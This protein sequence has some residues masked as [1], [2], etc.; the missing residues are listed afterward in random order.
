MQKIQLYIEGQRVDLF[1]DE[2]VVL[3]QT[4]QNVKDVQ[5]VFTDYSKTFTLPATKENN[6]IFKH[7]YNNSITN[8]FDGRGRVDATLELNHLKFRKGKIKL[9]GVDLRNNVPHTYKVR[10][11]GNT[12]TLKDLL[13]EDKLGALSDL[14]S[15][16]LVYNAANVKTKLKANPATSDIIAPLITHTK[17]LYY[18]ANTH[19]EG[20]S[21]LWY[22]SGSGTSHHHGVSWDDLKYAIRVDTIIQAI[23]TNYGISF[24]NDFFN[25]SNTPYY[26]L[27]MWLHR[28][29]GYVESPTATEVESLVNTWTTTSIGQTLSL[30]S[31]TSTLYIGGTPSRYTKLDLKLRTTS[32]FSYSVSVQLNG[33]EIYNSGS[34]TGNLDITK[35]NIGTSQGNYNV[36]IQS[37]QNITFSEVT[38]NIGYRLL[39]ESFNTYTSASFSHTNAFDF[40]ITQ[41][42]PE[43]KCIDF[44]TGIFKMF[45]LTSYI[46]NDTDEVIVKTLDDFYSDGVSYDIT[47]FVDRNKSSVNVALPFK[48]ITFE[49]GDTKTFLASKH[50]QLYNNTWG[51]I[52]YTSGEN[53]DGKIYKV[54]TPFSH[55]LY[56]RLI[57]LDTDA[58]TTVQYG[59]YVDDNQSPYYGK[60]LLF[61][62]ILQNTTSI[63]FLDTTSSHS[64]VTQYNIPSN[65]VA[66]SSST[67]KYNIN[68]NNEINEY[69]LDNTFT[70]TLFQAYHS[71]YISDVFD[72]TNR[73]TKVTAYLPLRILL[74]YTLADRFNI[75]GTT[76]KINSIKTNMLT[77]KSDLELLNDIYTPPAPAIPPDTTP[78]TAPIVNTSS[79]IRGTTQIYFCW[80]ASTDTGVGVKSYSVTQDSV[81]VQRVSATPYQD[82]YCVTITGLTSGTS[83]TFGITATDFNNNVSTTTNY[84]ISTL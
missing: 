11:T 41:Q 80:A 14:N 50:S 49:H 5:K 15:N 45:N 3:T 19:G 21:N 51:K 66:L 58:L 69:T 83:Y 54:K 74:N 12:V 46:D 29:K 8:G 25:S 39:V 53:L 64:E 48:E 38:W 4:I 35:D 52:E 67:S 30:M 63:S 60:P 37:A 22:E 23:E 31:N 55:M 28:K 32:G 36:I 73:L 40:I 16:T 68:F 1:D 7:Y 9:E 78:P 10:F 61:Y 42:I 6:K 70:N 56:E 18:E 77:G 57:D 13:G 76:Y 2:S 24:S 79:T 82:F 65:S 71:D 20:T 62:P 72:V 44:L 26:N 81:L 33:N 34:V 17:Q 59:W 84:T 27:F 75:S 43:I 47:E